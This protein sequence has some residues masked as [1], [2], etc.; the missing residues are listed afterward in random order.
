MYIDSTNV[1][2]PAGDQ[3]VATALRASVEP[4]LM[5][6][7]VDLVL[8]GHHHSYQRTCPVFN[9][10]CVDPNTKAPV[11]L[12]IGN[13]GAGLSQNLQ[14][15]AP[16]WIEYVNCDY[17]GYITISGTSVAYA[18]CRCAVLRRL[19]P[20]FCCGVPCAVSPDMLTVRAWQSRN[21]QLMD[22]FS[23]TRA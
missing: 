6:Y 11:H 22:S 5:Q 14:S 9:Q 8:W 13:A 19:T 12:V 4:L 16:E 17:Y 18:L 23:I 10:T 1:D 7:G 2:P 21:D 15:P 3:P 20:A